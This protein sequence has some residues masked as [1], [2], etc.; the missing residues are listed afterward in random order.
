MY[1][2]R[3]VA[4]SGETEGGC[5]YGIR[6][7]MEVVYGCKAPGLRPKSFC[8]YCCCYFGSA[9]L[10]LSASAWASPDGTAFSPCHATEQKYG[11][12]G[13]QRQEQHH[14]QTL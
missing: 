4:L 8:R 10:S 14:P 13:Q 6:W 5:G 1:G 2:T 11:G 3:S 9:L 7:C 12:R